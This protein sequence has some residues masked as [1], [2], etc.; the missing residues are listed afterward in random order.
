MGVHVLFLPKGRKSYICR[1]VCVCVQYTCLYVVCL[2]YVDLSD[3][4]LHTFNGTKL[5][6]YVSIKDVMVTT[7]LS[8]IL[9][10]FNNVI[11]D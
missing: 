7:M 9:Y 2:Q 4:I 1:R 3:V 6:Y 8:H 11:I 10:K 5:D